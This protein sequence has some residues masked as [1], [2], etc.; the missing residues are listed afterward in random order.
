M[1]TLEALPD[2]FTTRSANEAGLHFRDLYRF[3]DEGELLELS[4]GVFRKAD[5]PA[6]TWP[7]LL[8][9]SM[10]APLAVVCC[11]SSAEVH[12]LT[13]EIPR[14][15]QIAV[16]RGQRPPRIDYPPTEVF[17]FGATTFHLGLTEVEA[18]P[19]E[20]VRIYDPERTVVDLMRLRG[21]L[22]EP[23]ALSA[24]RR[25]LLRRGARPGQVLAFAR[26]LGV[27]GP[28]R[29]AVDAVIAE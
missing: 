3:R 1:G 5:A 10:R 11:V 9:V 24:L 26:E 22:G 19:G 7:D 14:E 4:R 12:D 8:A 28:V 27:L 17:R 18:A 16:Q 21:R 20:T 25:Y 13:D 6:P 29:A 15:I 23:L 2:T